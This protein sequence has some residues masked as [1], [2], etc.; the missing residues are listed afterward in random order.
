MLPPEHNVNLAYYT[1]HKKPKV[2]WLP[3][4]DHLN[5]DKIETLAI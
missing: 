1:C 4:Q 2:Q 3:V 5:S